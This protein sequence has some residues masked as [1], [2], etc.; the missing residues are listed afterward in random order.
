MPRRQKSIFTNQC[1]EFKILFGISLLFIIIY[2]LLP[3]ATSMCSLDTHILQNAVRPTLFDCVSELGSCM[4]K[5]T[6]CCIIQKTLRI[7][8]MAARRRHNKDSV[9]KGMPNLDRLIAPLPPH[10]SSNCA[11]MPDINKCLMFSMFT[12]ILVYW[13]FSH[14]HNGHCS[15]L[16]ENQRNNICVTLR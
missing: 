7:V 1:Q 3:F 5:V 11:C 10:C 6:S 4:K 12:L 8:S 16:V 14:Y 15:N 9:E 13:T 2:K